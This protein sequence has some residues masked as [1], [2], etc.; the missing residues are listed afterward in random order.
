MTGCAV[1]TAIKAGVSSMETLFGINL[2]NAE[3]RRMMERMKIRIMPKNIEWVVRIYR[4]G[5]H[6]A[7]CFNRPGSEKLFV[8][9]ILKKIQDLVICLYNELSR[10]N[11]D[12]IRS[13]QAFFS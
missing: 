9:A 11:V 4:N 3:F 10:D 8:H 7:K 1:K 13:V 2:A 12:F 6:S 5:S